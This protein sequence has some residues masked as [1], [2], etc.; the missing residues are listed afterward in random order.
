MAGAACCRFLWRYNP[1]GMTPDEEGQ[2]C[3]VLVNLGWLDT[4]QGLH[5]EGVRAI[6]ALRQCSSDEAIGI[7]R[8]LRLR[9]IIAE[10]S[11]PGGDAQKPG[12]QLRWVRPAHP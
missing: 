12:T 5:S 2:A 4:E 10:E 7:L 9:K 6:Q 1:N 11:A 8:D 3:D